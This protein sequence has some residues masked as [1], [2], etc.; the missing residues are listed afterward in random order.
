MEEIEIFNGFWTIDY[1]K[2]NPDK[3]FVYGDNDLRTGKGGQAIIRDLK[4]TIG[5][6]TKKAPNNNDSSFY[7]DSDLLNNKRLILEDI[8]KIKRI[9][10]EGKTIVLSNGGYGT[11]LSKMKEK[12]PLTFDFLCNILKY[13]LGFNNENGKKWS[14]IPSHYEMSTA[15]NITIDDDYKSEDSLT[16]NGISDAFESIINEYKVSI[17]STDTY[18]MGSMINITKENC[19]YSLMCM[20]STDSYPVS[21]M[22]KSD[23]CFFEACE[24]REFIGYQT[25][26]KF[27]CKID[28]TGVVGFGNSMV[29]NK[30]EKINRISNKIDDSKRIDILF[31]KINN[32]EEMLKLLLNK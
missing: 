28:N 8:L 21:S 4:N 13:N 18:T 27:I 11:G 6:R 2:S 14:R 12:S 31:D 10:L 24:P 25:Q 5:I 1:V 17:I 22:S 16:R 23:L 32:I 15:I 7:N 26:I 20:I 29:G 3:I 30:I 9:I 19:D